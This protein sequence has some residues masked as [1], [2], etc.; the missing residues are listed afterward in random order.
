MLGPR[1]GLPRQ[2]GVGGAGRPPDLGLEYRLTGGKRKLVGLLKSSRFLR[3]KY[4]EVGT[5]EKVDKTEVEEIFEALGEHTN[6]LSLRAS[7]MTRRSRWS[8]RRSWKLVSGSRS[9]SGKKC[10][11]T[12]KEDEYE[13]L[14]FDCIITWWGECLTTRFTRRRGGISRIMMVVR[15]VKGGV[16]TCEVMVKFWKQDLPDKTH[17]E[18]Q[19][20]GGETG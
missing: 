3:V 5:R 12:L 6:T 19:P 18:L 8:C 2:Q 4:V 9:S 1:D 14:A 7:S 15:E 17:E 20:V 13:T 16:W 10:K 11:R